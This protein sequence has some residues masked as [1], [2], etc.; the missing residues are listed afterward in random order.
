M[1]PVKRSSHCENTGRAKNS[2]P[3]AG[4]E[5]RRSNHLNLSEGETNEGT[6]IPVLG[7]LKVRGKLAPGTNAPCGDQI[8]SV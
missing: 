3:C 1:T 7:F 8:K 2:I 6:R 5:E 4:V